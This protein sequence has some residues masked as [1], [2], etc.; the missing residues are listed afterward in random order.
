MKVDD[1]AFDQSELDPVHDASTTVAALPS[2]L[3]ESLKSPALRSTAPPPK[4]API[5][6]ALDDHMLDLAVFLDADEPETLQLDTALLV[7]PPPSAP[8]EL[9]VHAPPT[10]FDLVENELAQLPRTWRVAGA[11]LAV[12]MLGGALLALLS[13]A[14]G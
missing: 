6:V 8:V 7:Q 1:I 12:L 3:L 10:A 2:E 11:T 4:P 9:Y 14:F 13:L 5:A